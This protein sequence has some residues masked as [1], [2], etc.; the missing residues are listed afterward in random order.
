VDH[1]ETA[2]KSIVRH[3]AVVEET[4][5][6]GNFVTK[7]ILS[8]LLKFSWRQKCGGLCRKERASREIF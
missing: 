1:T 7:C 5:I 3:F 4:L 2:L 8:G 6:G